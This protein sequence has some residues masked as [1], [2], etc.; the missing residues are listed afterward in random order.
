MA[1]RQPDR[2]GTAHTARSIRR[3]AVIAAAAALVVGLAAAGPALAQNTYYV[4]P[5]GDD[6]KDGL[7]PQTAWKTVAKVNAT[8]FAPG[9]QILFQRDG[10]WRES[11]WASSSGTSAQP[12]VYGAY[13]TGARPT[14]WG[15]DVLN[16]GNF[17]KVGGT[18]STYSIPVSQTVNTFLADHEFYRSSWVLTDQSSDV[19]TNLNYV[20]ANSNTWYYTGGQLY[21]NTGGVD[22]Q[23][24]P[25][26]Y[27]AA[28]RD[29]VVYSNAR[30]NLVF[31]DLIV[32]ESAKYNAGYAFRVSGSSNVRI[33]DCEAYRAGKHHF[34]VINSTG[35]VGED[36]YAT[37]ALPDQ[38]PFGGATA[39][40]S[41][42]DQ[43]RSG[44]TSQWINTLC[45]NYRD[46]GAGTNYAAF[47]SHGPGM[48]DI[49][50]QNMVSRGCEIT[51]YTEGPGERVRI[52]DTTIENKGL[53][54]W[55]AS[56]VLVDGLTIIGSDGRI[57]L[58]GSDNVLQN[59]LV[60]GARPPDGHGWNAVTSTGGNNTIRFNTIVLDPATADTWS[61]ICLASGDSNTHVYGNLIAGTANAFKVGGSGAFDA[62]Y[63]FYLTD[64]IFRLSD[65]STLTLAQWQA[66]GNDAHGLDGEPMFADPASGDYS[67]LAGSPA[68]DKVLLDPISM[69]I[70][71]D[72]AGN[73]RL[74]GV[75]ADMGAYEYIPE[76]AAAGLLCLIAPILLKR[77]RG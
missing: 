36:L 11:L 41:Y 69:G 31:R 42:S 38:R 39:Y 35:F 20:N 72:H 16:N 17:Q 33:E 59:S 47:T 77:R 4:S 1:I 64:P 58:K 13:G 44:D 22:P 9:S 67:L 12:I 26:V 5:G 23:A 27:T 76:P 68:I 54:L 60:I 40:V 66:L 49:L 50:I 3:V 51:L 2:H 7:T 25:K 56:N 21:V 71:L 53:V 73:P 30:N 6:A 34:G 65:G 62:D 48:G 19:T 10:E 29:D 32:Q 74:F 18:T 61:A 14:F 24:A 46:T 63:N 70:L 55:D 37:I 45:E 52:I 15:S 75:A 43:S 28:I 8:A 57:V